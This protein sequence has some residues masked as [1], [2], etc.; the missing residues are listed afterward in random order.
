MSDPDRIHRARAEGMLPELP[1]LHIRPAADVA[2][3]MIEGS[4]AWQPDRIEHDALAARGATIVDTIAGPVPLTIVHHTRNR[5]ETLGLFVEAWDATEPG[6]LVALTGDRTDGMDATLKRI[7]TAVEPEGSVAKSHGKLAV[8][9]RGD[10]RPAVFETFLEEAAP[11]RNA[12]GF[13]TRPGL[14]SADGIDDASRLLAE[15]FDERLKGR[16]ADLGAGWGWLSLQ[17]LNR[18][19]GIESVTLFEADRLALDLARGNLAD[20]RARYAWADVARLTPSVTGGRFDVI[21]SNPPFHSGR[22]GQP[23]L[24]QGFIEAAARLLAPSGSALFVANRH[25]PYERTIEANFAFWEE[26]DGDARF[27]LFRTRKPRPRR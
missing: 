20:D 16:A 25:L 2:G 1:A 8:M 3:A 5:A 13:L 4:R 14:F 21:V 17:L 7:R 19:P 6:G 26:L 10:A 12:D 22:A 9:R 11:S 23:A 15:R 18:S 24:G 27:K